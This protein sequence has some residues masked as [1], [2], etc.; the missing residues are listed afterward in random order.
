[1]LTRLV[2]VVGLLLAVPGWAHARAGVQTCPDGQRVL[3][4]KD[5]GAERW[6]IMYDMGTHDVMGNVFFTSGEPPAFV[7]CERTATDGNPNVRNMMMTFACYGADACATEP[8]DQRDWHFISDVTLP[9]DF[10]MPPMGD[11]GMGMR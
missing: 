9:G 4:S 3:V 11:P 7:W 1:M 2:V 10:F 8:C 6:A 5:V